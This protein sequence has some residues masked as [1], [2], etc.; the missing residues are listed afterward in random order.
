MQEID[1]PAAQVV[2]N[3][4]QAL[5]SGNRQQA[6]ALLANDVTINE[7]GNVERSA[8]E[9]QQHHMAADMAYLADMQVTTPEH[10]V[11]ID[12]VTANL[13]SHNHTKGMYK[14]KARDQQG[15]ETIIL[16]LQNGQWKI[17]HI[18]WS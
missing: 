15:M 12:G 10:Q 4:H 9:Y 5:K 7:G 2:V 6:R 18:H 3:F 1:T 16:Q 17:K 11:N 8:D 14:G 13:I